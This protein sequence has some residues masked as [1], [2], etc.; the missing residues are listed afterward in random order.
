MMPLDA[1]RRFYAEEIEAVSNVK[2]RAL[3]D[4][5]ATVPRERFLRPGPWTIR[6][7][8]D[9]Q[10]VPRQTPD[11]DPWHVYH[12]LA[13]AIEPS[14]QLF[15]G[16]PGLLA[17]AI[18]ALALAPNDRVLHIGP[19]TGYYTA[20]IASC[21]GPGGYVRAIEV[22]AA[23]AAEAAA[24]LASF[25][26]VDVRQG[27]CSEPLDAAFDAILVNAGVT[28]PLPDWLDALAPA[29]RAIVPLT[30][31]PHAFSPIGKGLLIALSRTTEAAPNVEYAARVVTFVAIY[32]AIGVRDEA[33]NAQLAQALRTN[34]FPP[35]RRLRRDPH[36]RVASCW[37]HSDACCFSC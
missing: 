23:L 37:L 32:S 31:V 22:D 27:D 34:P 20:L 33:L 35:L 7:E 28:H 29:G 26:G 2:H 13:I 30:A 24:N 8:A 10:A 25:P 16:A 6:G 15:N 12:N 17:L 19:G 1:R 9:L 3:V 11:G 4:A 36:E 21:V 5:L 14:R 18:D